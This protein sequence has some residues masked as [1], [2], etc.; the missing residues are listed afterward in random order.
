MKLGGESAGIR[1]EPIVFKRGD[2]KFIFWVTAQ[3]SYAAFNDMC[4][5]P[6]PPSYKQPGKKTL[7]KDVN[8][9]DYKRACENH[10]KLFTDWL[11]IASL[12]D[13]P[14]L[15]WDEV[16]LNGKNAFKTWPKW[17]DE[18]RAFGLCERELVQIITKVSS[19]NALNDEELEETIESFLS[20]SDQ[21]ELLEQDSSPNGEVQNTS[22]GAS[23][24][25]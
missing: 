9:P 25:K 23:A 6:E 1:R 4:P 18:L 21:K 13:T 16:K 10:A 5:M 17:Q 12:N 22:S 24:N 19:V 3:P 20:E 11:V 7:I 14:G 15:E 2:K 8:D